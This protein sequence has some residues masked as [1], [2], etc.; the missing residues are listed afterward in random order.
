VVAIQE[1]PIN[2]FANTIAS[3]DWIPIYPTTHSNDPTKT[4][5]L[6][7]I[8]STILTEK[9]QQVDFPSG[10]ITVIQISG[11]WGTLTIYNIYNNCDNNDTIQLL[12]EFNRRHEADPS[13]N[14]DNTKITM[15]LGDFNRH[16][17]HW[18]DPSDTRLFTRQAVSNAEVLISAVAEAGLDMALPPGIPTHI[19]NVTKKWT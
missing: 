10:D 18:D 3:R 17:P 2:T 19:H 7:L 1:P 16:H 9:W 5:S 6:L 15:R 14:P 13:S 8:R 11:A 12:E 4:C